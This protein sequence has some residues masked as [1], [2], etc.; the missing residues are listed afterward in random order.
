MARIF[1]FFAATIKRENYNHK[2]L[3]AFDSSAVMATLSQGELINNSESEASRESSTK[4]AKQLDTRSSLVYRYFLEKGRKTFTAW[5][6]KEDY[7]TFP[8]A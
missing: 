4:K 5:D 2:F 7:D 8:F 6:K 3:D 1:V